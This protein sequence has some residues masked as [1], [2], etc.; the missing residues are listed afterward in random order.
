MDDLLL[1]SS[2][3]EEGLQLLNQVFELLDKAGLKLNLKKVFVS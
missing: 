3:V 1:P 2:S